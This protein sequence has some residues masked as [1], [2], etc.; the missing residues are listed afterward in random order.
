MSWLV[1]ALLVFE[2]S[3]PFRVEGL[4]GLDSRVADNCPAVQNALI[5]RVRFPRELQDA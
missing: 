1:R 3:P 5:E 2:V 4:P